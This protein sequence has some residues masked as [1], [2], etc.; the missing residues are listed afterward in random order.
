MTQG[1]HSDCMIKVSVN[2]AATSFGH[3]LSLLDKGEEVMVLDQDRPIARIIRCEPELGER[4]KVG[5]I[6]SPTVS[7]EADCFEPMT[8]AELR[9][10]GL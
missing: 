4:P 3:W 8:G 6:T 7:Y 1:G 10:W 5:T 2:E 9:Q